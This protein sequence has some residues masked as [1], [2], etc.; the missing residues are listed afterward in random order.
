M[1]GLEVLVNI[2]FESEQTDN[3]SEVYSTKSVPYI[4][5]HDFF[6]YEDAYAVIKD[7]EGVAKPEIDSGYEIAAKI[8]IGE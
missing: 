8:E 7:S 1:N 3:V 2:E 5:L 6:L 4:S